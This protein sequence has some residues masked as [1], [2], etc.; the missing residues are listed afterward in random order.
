MSCELWAGKLDAY[1]DGEGAREDLLAM[2]EHLRTCPDCAREALATMQLKRATQLAAQ[3]F[4]PSPEFRLRMEKMLR[5]NRK[6]AGWLA[7][8]PGLIAVAAVLLLALASSLVF[9]RHVEREQA[10][11]ELL[12]LHVATLASANPVDVI[13]TDRHT[14]KPW[15]QGK[16]PFSFNL[17]ELANTQFKLLGGRVAYLNHSP[18]AQLLFQTGKHQISVFIVQE[19][20]GQR[21]AISAALNSGAVRE[22]G[23][24]METWSENGLRYTVVSDTNAA[25]V[26]ALSELL[27]AAGH[28]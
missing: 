22:K 9:T 28:S 19:Q 1:V 8:R 27:T 24:N 10:L 25:D 15:F 11:A 21:G 26:H 23:F 2:E 20:D 3:R 17:P 14:V 4:T 7:W 12:D 5:K 13:S 18:A 16:L 6:P